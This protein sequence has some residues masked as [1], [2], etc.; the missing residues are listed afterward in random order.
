VKT[1]YCVPDRAIVGY[2]YNPYLQVST[3]GSVEDGAANRRKYDCALS[4]S[5]MIGKRRDTQCVAR[6]SYDNGPAQFSC[7]MKQ[8]FERYK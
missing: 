3:F 8:P 2:D 6:G 5:L 7:S 4:F 1:E